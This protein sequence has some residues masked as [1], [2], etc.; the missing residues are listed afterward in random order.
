VERGIPALALGVYRGGGAHT[1]EE[2]VLPRS[3][4]EGRKALLAFLK[5]LGVG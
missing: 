3:L 5:A 1:E 4:L 2:W